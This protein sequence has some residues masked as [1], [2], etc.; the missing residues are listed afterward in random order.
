MTV[1]VVL[2]VIAGI[3]ITGA[4]HE[5]GFADVCDA[6]GGG[7]TKES[8]LGIMKDSRIGAYG[9]IGVVS[10]VLLKLFALMEIA[11]IDT[12]LAVVTI[13]NAHASSR[14]IAS[15]FV[16]THEYT[17]D[18][19]KSK[20]KPLA[21]KQLSGYEVSY[22]FLFAL[23]PLFLFGNWYG[24]LAF[25]MA[26][27]AKIYLGYY[28]NKRIGGYTGDCLGATQ[29]VAEVVFYLSILAAGNL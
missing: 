27:M 19:D 29:Q 13:V 24:F 9:T 1:A 16:D 12:W 25:P 7:W 2:S 18:L 20:S 14:F 28:F 10:I 21:K 5:D 26:Y 17:Q 11:R 4:F 8:V 23:L 15:T 6:F 3:W 22:S